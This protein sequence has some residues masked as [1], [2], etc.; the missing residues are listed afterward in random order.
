[1]DINVKFVIEFGEAAMN[2]ISSLIPGS[3][4]APAIK[5]PSPID[6]QKEEFK[7]LISK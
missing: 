2:F 6:E 7:K 3:G 1:M 4:S 5:Q